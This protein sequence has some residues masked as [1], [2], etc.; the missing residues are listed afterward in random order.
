MPRS[1]SPLALKLCGLL[2]LALAA[3]FVAHPLNLL[4]ARARLG[5]IPHAAVAS[6]RGCASQL[7]A[8]VRA[9]GL[10]SLWRGSGFLVAWR[11]G[12]R[13]P[14]FLLLGAGTTFYYVT[15]DSAFVVD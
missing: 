8:I 4:S 3:D 12:L 2:S 10:W 11:W 1:R 14:L 15:S 9:E 6:V 5:M 13:V 7:A